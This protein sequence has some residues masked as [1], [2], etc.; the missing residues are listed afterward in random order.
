MILTILL[1]CL[2]PC[3]FKRSDH[4]G[5]FIHLLSVWSLTKHEICCLYQIDLVTFLWKRNT[6][7]LTLQIGKSRS[8][9][10]GVLVYKVA[11]DFR[12]RRVLKNLQ[13]LAQLGVLSCWHY[14]R[15]RRDIT[16]H[17]D[18]VV[19]CNSLSSFLWWGRWSFT[20]C[21]LIISYIF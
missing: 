15:R 18:L 10:R 17:C 3:I 20:I 5:G 2:S 9:L 6:S 12:C 19:L 7:D 11:R 16:M 1:R 14:S 13:T 4:L 21:Y 8:R